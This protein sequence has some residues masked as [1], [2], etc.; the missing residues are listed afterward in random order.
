MQ[1]VIDANPV[2]SILVSP[3]KPI[4]LLFLE[5]LELFAPSLLFDEIER[6]K[7]EIIE[8][9]ELSQKEIEELINIIK[10]RIKVIPEEEFIKFRE[11]AEEICPDKKDITY[12]ALALYLNCFLWSN[13][14]KLKEQNFIKVYATHEL[15]PLFG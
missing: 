15:I 4:E 6:N 10:Q 2:I 7:E 3:G 13:E 14:K 11:K 1:L 5:E 12:F 9:S 8:K